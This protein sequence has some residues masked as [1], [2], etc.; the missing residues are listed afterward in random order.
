MSTDLLSSFPLYNGITVLDLKSLG[1]HS[2]FP[3]LCN[4]F[5]SARRR[6]GPYFWIILPV[7]NILLETLLHNWL[8]VFCSSSIIGFTFIYNFRGAY[9]KTVDGVLQFSSWMKCSFR[10]RVTSLKWD[11]CW[12]FE[13]LIA[14]L[15]FLI[16]GLY[17]ALT[18]EQRAFL[19]T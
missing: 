2:S 6:M 5:N 12:P 13:G 1:V 14:M 10:I 9:A 18:L 7:A 17:I 15:S 16:T 11:T 4:K 19:L 8:I 3:I